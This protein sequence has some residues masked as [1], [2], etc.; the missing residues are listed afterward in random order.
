MTI[1]L[2]MND[3]SEKYIIKKMKVMLFIKI[4]LKTLI[5]QNFR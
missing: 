2:I 5:S 3:F 1:C 4:N